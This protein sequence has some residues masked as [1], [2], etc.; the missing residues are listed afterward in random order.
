MSSAVQTK[1]FNSYPEALSALAAALS[2]RVFSPDEYY[3]V[4]CPDRYTQTVEQALFCGENGGGALDCEVLTLSRLARRIAPTAKTLQKEGGVMI[5]ARAIAAVKQ[6]LHY[7]ARAAAFDDFAPTAYDTIQQIAAS[8]AQISD[9]AATGSTKIKLNDLALIKA[10]YDKIKGEYSDA[11]DKLLALING[12]ACSFVKSVHFF[13]IGYSDMTKLIARVFNVLAMH[14]KSFALYDAPPSAVRR[15]S[16]DLLCAPDHVSE[17]KQVAAEIRDYVY[18]GGRY[19]DI[20]IICNSPRALKR[21]LGEYEIPTYADES[22][23]LYNT[24][25]LTALDNVYKLHVATKKRNAIDCAALVALCKNPFVGCD[26]FDAEKLQHEVSTRALGYVPVDYEFSIGGRRAAERALSVVRAFSAC[27][28]FCSA[29]RRVLEIC[30]FVGMQRG[31]ENGGTD[32][33]TP[34]IN[35]VELLSRY[36]SGDFDTD[37][38]SFFSASQTVDVNTLPRERDCVTVTMPNALRLTAVKKLFITDF[39]EGVM[40]PAISDTGLISDSELN[41]LGGVIEPTV[42]KRNRQS[43]DELRAVVQNAGSVYVTYS[44]S[45]GRRAAFISELAKNIN[46]LD[47]TEIGDVLLKTHDPRFVSKYAS[48]PAAARE[49]VARKLSRHAGSVGA[50]T[51]DSGTETAPFCDRVDLPKRTTLSVSELSHWFKCPYFRFLRDTVGIAERRH[52]FG[53]PDFGIVVHDFMQRFVKVKPYDCSE[54][55]VKKIIDEVL[56]ENDI[57]LDA[58]AY[59]RMLAD[60]VDYAEVNAHILE[61]GTYD[62][63]Q[64]EY[65]FGGKTL[66]TKS[67]LEFIGFIDRFDVCGNRARIIDYKTGDKKFD[68][69][70]CL[71]G[72]DMQLPLYAY[73]I[74]YDVT[75]MFYVRSGKRYYTGKPERAMS[76]CMVMDT[77]IALEYDR[78]LKPGGEPSDVIPARLK[79]DKDGVVSFY[80][81]KSSAMLDKAE[82][83]RLVA[84]CKSNADVAADEIQD[85]YICRSPVEGACEHCP[86]VGFCGGGTPRVF[87]NGA[88]EEEA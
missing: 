65:R 24:P 37:A 48:V 88:E 34:I 6:D 35:L 22:K 74:P 73:A 72:T 28:D 70:S 39:N 3:V 12:A 60:A 59:S 18:R 2:Q 36:G 33:V 79:V 17:Y 71:D 53:A 23:P 63:A 8:D 55:A 58:A 80:G 49:L 16:V 25:P 66:G 64:T 56:Q 15:D 1:Q 20:A 77:D 67:P 40:P 29:V 47:C 44:A 42:R 14:A 10:E 62:V 69:R 26:T 51:K 9:I 87:D 21:I 85:G 76:G 61:K 41:A 32:V 43:R 46:E 81:R 11:P 52:G 68:I 38:K 4:L 75:G 45:D 78:D 54:A 13:A 84:A 19:D 50:A 27:N 83:D 7:Y 31:R 57:T 86:Y 30:D 82:F 5:T